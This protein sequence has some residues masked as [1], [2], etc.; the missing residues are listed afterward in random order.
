MG[1]LSLAIWT[2]IAIGALL[3]LL[4]RESQV[5][6]VRWIALIGSLVSFLVTLP[7]YGGFRL[8]TPEMQFVENHSWIARFN[9]NDHLGVDGI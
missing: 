5:Q 4:S 7:L 3:L 1:W 8:G 2:P 6:L 9:V